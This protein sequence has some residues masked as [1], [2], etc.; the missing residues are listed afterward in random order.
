MTVPSDHAAWFQ[1]TFDQLTTNI[2]QA[3]LG[4]RNVVQL[5][6]TCLVLL[7]IFFSQRLGTER[8]ASFFGPV[9]LLWF[10]SLAALGVYGIVQAPQVI[11]G[12]DPR[13]G[14]MLMVEHPGLAGVR[15]WFDGVL[16]A[17]RI[18]ALADRHA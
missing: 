11:A 17:D 14:I 10:G 3:V 9:M 6:L 7:A 5:A 8:I 16:P 2:E 15:A 12:L 1:Q 18:V 13:H 4:K